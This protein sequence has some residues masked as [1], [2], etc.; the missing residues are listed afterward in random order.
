METQQLNHKIRKVLN[1]QIEGQIQ[2]KNE[3]LLMYICA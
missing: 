2:E 1:L 3:L